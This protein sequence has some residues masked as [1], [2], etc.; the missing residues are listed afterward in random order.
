[1]QCLCL[2]FTLGLT[3]LR[4]RESQTDCLQFRVSAVQHENIFGA[5]DESGRMIRCPY[6]LLYRTELTGTL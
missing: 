3:I 5:Y 6:L 4:I 2:C 1:M